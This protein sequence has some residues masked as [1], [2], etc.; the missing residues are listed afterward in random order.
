VPYHLVAV[1]PG[2]G[3]KSVFNRDHAQVVNHVVE[4]IQDGTL[5]TRSGSSQRTRQA[6][7]LRI[8][9][10]DGSYNT[11][12]GGSF[13]A[14]IAGKRNQYAKFE[15]EANSRLQVKRTRRVFIVMPIQGDEYGGQADRSVYLEYTARFAAIEAVLDQFDCVA[16]RIDREAPIGSLV[17]QIKR[18]IGRAAFVVADLTD[19]RPSCYFE[20]GYAEALGKP[21]IYVASRES[22]LTPGAETRIHFDIH[23]NVQFFGNHT[24]LSKRVTDVIKRNSEILLPEPPEPNQWVQFV[25]ATNYGA[26]TVA[27]GGGTVIGTP[28]SSITILPSE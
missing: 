21:V 4:F 10:T 24:E 12:T 27:Y 8:F 6:Y 15:K 11:R 9:E 28:V 25:N 7:E 19:E 3:R 5:T 23:Q 2:G 20:A 1:L 16:I 18:E 26:A 17:D 13:D 14:F 22:V